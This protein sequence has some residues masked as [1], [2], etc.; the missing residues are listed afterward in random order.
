MRHVQSSLA[1]LPVLRSETQGLLL[2]ALMMDDD[3]DHTITGLAER[4]GVDPSTVLREVDRLED[5]GLL[6]THRVGRTRVVAVSTDSPLVDPLRELVTRALGPVPLLTRAVSAIPGVEQAFI[7]GSWAAGS[8]GEMPGTAADIDLLVIGEP[9][10]DEVLDAVIPI[11]RRLGRSVD[12]TFRTAIEWA[13]ESDPFVA[14]VRSRPM[15][16]L[17]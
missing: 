10:R 17:R 6:V 16:E 12:V 8:A 2:A 4:I 14:T 15:I 11:E 7:F 13:D 5:A 1:L 9:S 3:A